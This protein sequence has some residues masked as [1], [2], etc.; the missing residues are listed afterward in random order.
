IDTVLQEY[1]NKW[2]LGRLPRIVLSILR[3]AYC[4]IKYLDDIPDSVAINE[5]VELAK[6]FAGEEDASFVNGVLGGISRGTVKE[7]DKATTQDVQ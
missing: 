6:I 5:A 3:A 4:E 2:K 1:S 7:A